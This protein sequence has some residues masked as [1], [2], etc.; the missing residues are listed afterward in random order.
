MNSEDTISE[1]EEWIEES[2]LDED[3]PPSDFYVET[4]EH[5]AIIRWGSKRGDFPTLGTSSILCETHIIESGEKRGTM[6][7][8]DTDAETSIDVE[9]LAYKHFLETLMV[10]CDKGYEIET[11]PIHG[12][13]FRIRV[14]R[15][16]TTNTSIDEV[17]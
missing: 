4:Y 8:A 1:I 3:A 15:L 17:I 7:V 14:E 2:I 11:K 12:E 10:D 5:S 6:I 13:T 16:T 9:Q